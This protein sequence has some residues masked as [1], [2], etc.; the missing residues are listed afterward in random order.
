MAGAEEA[1]PRRPR[2]I[3]RLR[4]GPSQLSEVDDNDS[5]GVPAG[6]GVGWDRNLAIARNL[7]DVARRHRASTLYE[8][9]HSLYP[10]VPRAITSDGASRLGSAG[11]SGHGVERRLARPRVV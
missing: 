3:H 9:R 8:A 6:T 4:H 5:I 11:L 10:P 2:D 1:R 7:H